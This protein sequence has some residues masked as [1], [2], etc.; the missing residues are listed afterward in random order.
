MRI[1]A[2]ASMPRLH[3]PPSG[4]NRRKLQ[5]GFS[6]PAETGQGKSCAFEIQGGHVKNPKLT[7]TAKALHAFALK[8]PL[9]G[10]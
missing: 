7:F 10:T 6:P 1:Q 3:Q 4:R 5:R 9:V 8:G 2:R